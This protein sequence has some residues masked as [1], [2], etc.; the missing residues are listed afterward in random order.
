MKQRAR[1]NWLWIGG[2]GAVLLAVAY[3]NHAAILQSWSQSSPTPH[4]ALTSEPPRYQRYSLPESE[5]HTIVLPAQSRF[6]VSIALSEKTSTIDQFAR[7]NAAI[8]A[9]N[10]GFFDPQNQKTT[11]IVIQKGKLIADP[12]QNERLTENPTLQAYLA[13]IFNRSEFR[14]YDCGR[15]TQ[16]AI[17][18]RST[19]VPQSC[20]LIDAIGGGPQLLPVLT[21]QKEGFVDRATGRDAIGIDQ[22]NA[23]S[24]IGILSNGSILLV[25]AAQKSGRPNSGVTLS[26]LADFMRRL[27]VQQALNLDGGTSSALFAQGQIVYGKVDKAGDRVSRPVKSAILVRRDE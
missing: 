5:I 16:Y 19:V 1:K 23:R 15:S 10:A 8:A 26:E 9:L 6:R 27:G 18:P 20:Q 22:R 21:A 24:A 4:A 2:I 7:S 14:R 11:S 25:M 12:K 13:Q 17:V 3:L